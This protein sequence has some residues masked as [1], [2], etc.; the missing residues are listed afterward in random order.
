MLPEERLSLK[1]GPP[2]VS[3][4]LPTGQGR[5]GA[6]E[7][8][9]EDIEVWRVTKGRRKKSEPGEHLCPAQAS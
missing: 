1:S 5:G 4:V 7:L 9:P 8:R 3:E 2:E 6:V